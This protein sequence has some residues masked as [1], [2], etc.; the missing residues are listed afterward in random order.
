MDSDLQIKATLCNSGDCKS[1]YFTETTGIYDVD[2]NPTGYGDPNPEVLAFENGANLALTN[3]NGDT[4]IFTGTTYGLLP[5]DDDTYKFQILNTQLGLGADDKITDGLWYCTYTITQTQDVLD[6]IVE[7][8]TFPFLISCSADCC[9]E[10]LFSGLDITCGCSNDK[11]MVYMRAKIALE[12]A[13]NAAECGN[14]TAMQKDLDYVDFLCK[15]NNCGC[16]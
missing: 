11:M 15:T 9:L 7:S 3:P 10:R 14:L 16:S 8:I 4:F 1:L 12:A 5:T 13:K 6:P 2:E